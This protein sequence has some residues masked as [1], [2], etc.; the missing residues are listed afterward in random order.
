MR[1]RGAGLGAI[2]NKNLAQ[3]KYKNKGAEIAENDFEQMSKQLE[4]FK[5]NLEE[6]ARNHKDDI[7]KNPE[8]R[9]Q[10]QEMCASIG[11]D[12]LASGKGFWS[13]MLG[14]G[15]F[16]YELGVQI[17]EVCMATNHR[18]GGLMTLDDLRE[19]L[20]RSSGRS[21]QDVSSDDL[22]RAIKKLKVLGNGF[23]VIP[24]GPG[25]YMVQSVP[26]ELSMDH[27][28]VIQQAEKTGFVTMKMLKENLKWEDE[29]SHMALDYLLKEGQAW[30]DN[31]DKSGM[32]LYWLPGL[33]SDT[34]AAT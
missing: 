3:A 25:R 28:T 4:A 10:F 20:I 18:N 30:V 27:T 17:I 32:T 9:S 19:T 23:S 21:R 16:Y 33:F 2:K 34:N 29:R 5:S 12:P 6:F 7:R 13:E 22:L 1:R 26:G 8:F 24:M 14:V 15:D 31:Q 11:V